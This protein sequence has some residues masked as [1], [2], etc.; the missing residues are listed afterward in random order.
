[1]K[2]SFPS[3]ASLLL[4][5]WGVCLPLL[6]QATPPAA[7]A[8]RPSGDEMLRT[9]IET[10][11]RYETIVAKLRQRAELFDRQIVGT[12]AYLQGPARYQLVRVELNL[13]MDDKTSTLLQV[14]DGKQLWTQRNLLGQNKLTCLDAQRVLAAVQKNDAARPRLTTDGLALGGLPRLLRELERSF[15]FDAPHDS[16]LGNLPVHMLVGQW[17]ADF[18]ARLLPDQA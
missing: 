18:L 7:A 13:Q 12:G 16:K 15:R 14:C 4:A 11:S 10:L 3:L 6:A 8:P 1:M 5:C 9:A 17:Q 2:I